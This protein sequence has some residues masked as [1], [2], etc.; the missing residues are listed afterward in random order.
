VRRPYLPVSGA[1]LLIAVGLIAYSQ[2]WA[3][4]ADEGFH[5]LA[6]QLIA[7]GKRPYLDFLFPQTPLNAYWNAA[8]IRIIGES[9]RV[10]HVMAALETAAAV[11]LVAD[12]MFRRSP[13]PRW[14]TFAA[15]FVAC[16]IGLNVA[17]VQFGAIAQAYGLC[18]FLI[19]AAFRAAVIA[20][21]RQSILPT[22]LAGFLS[23][24]AA[25][26]SL[27][28]A[29]IAPV[30]LV[31]ILLANRVGSR[32]SK[33]AAFAIGALIAFLPLLWLFV[34]SPRHVIFAVL[35]YH[36]FY[37][38]EEWSGALTHD[39]DVV[40]SWIDCGQALALVLL[41]IGGLVFV[42]RSGWERSQKNE[43]YLCGLLALVETIHLLNAHPTF[44]RYFLFTVPF[45]AVPAAVALCGLGELLSLPRAVV[46][47]TCCLMAVGL[48]K[49]LYEGRDD[50]AW[51]DME[52]VAAKVDE[53][54]PRG[55]PLYADESVY[56]LTRRPPPPGMEHQNSHKLKLQPA[57]AAALHV[58]PRAE[59]ERMMKAGTFRTV[60][61]SSDDEIEQ[62]GLPNLY[63]KKAEISVCTIFWDRK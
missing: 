6:A 23:S 28:T 11:A 16:A 8:W 4:A 27:L 60:E 62:F 55:A 36:L 46:I 9:W 47:V 51:S 59:L 41:A 7:R 50:V 26:S 44:S 37:R 61:T 5:L 38:Q 35:Q 10:T 29:A 20:V 63:S 32:I 3:Y 40:L 25:A 21:E 53:V 22:A 43:F 39:L 57:E 58:V 45:L 56:F 42:S 24:A 18:L 34:Q 19:V 14:R 2:T 12:Y 33:F 13:E 30:L 52:K 54:T 48:G 15:L 17:V 49:R 1:V 31:W